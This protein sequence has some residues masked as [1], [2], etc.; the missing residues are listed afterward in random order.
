MPNDRFSQGQLYGSSIPG[1]TVE[2]V[3]TVEGLLFG[4]FLKALDALE[5]PAPHLYVEDD[6]ND[7]EQADDGILA[8]ATAQI[9]A[10][11]KQGVVGAV[12]EQGVEQGVE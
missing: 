11:H 12:H 7:E 4:A 9:A 10:Y 3:L 1:E 2:G 5:T 6:E 8:F